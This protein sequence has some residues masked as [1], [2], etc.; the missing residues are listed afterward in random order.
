VISG[1]LR[2]LTALLVLGSNSW[3]VA[4][5][6]PTTDPN[7]S[8]DPVL[9][10][11]LPPKPPSTAMREGTMFLDVVVSDVADKPMPGL[12]PWD[13]KLL[14]NN[15][16]AKI[17]SFHSFGEA[18]AKPDPPVEVILVIDELNLPFQQVAFVKSEI[19]RFLA[20]NGG[21]LAQPV[22]LMLLNET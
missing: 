13:F 17:M 3:V 8:P 9:V 16:S 6:S 10:H 2:F 4:Q 7:N 5:V 20:Q 14:D 18:A 12:E 22:S 19:S 15:R 21:H 1:Y 11:R